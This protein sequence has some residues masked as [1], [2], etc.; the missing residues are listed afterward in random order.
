MYPPCSPP[1]YSIPFPLPTLT[2][3]PP[4]SPLPLLPPL[5]SLSPP[6]PPP[7][8]S[9]SSSSPTLASFTSVSS[10]GVSDG[11]E[12][13]VDF[14]I[15]VLAAPFDGVGVAVALGGY[16]PTSLTSPYH[17]DVWT[18]SPS[19]SFPPGAT[20][21]RWYLNTALAPWSP[22]SSQSTTTDGERL[23]LIMTGGVDATINYNDVW[24]MSFDTG[25][26]TTPA[27]ILWYRLTPTPGYAPR[28]NAAFY[29]VNDWLFL[30][31]GAQGTSQLVTADYDD[32]W[33][34]ADYGS[35]WTQWPQTG[36]GTGRYGVAGYSEARRLFVLGGAESDN[37]V[38]LSFSNQVY[39]GYW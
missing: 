1:F 12:S 34:S 36:T 6:L 25:T 22:R 14:S 19:G 15:N 37:V 30:Y 32:V 27:A 10:A 18:F 31:G 20:A 26:A 3:H 24:Q 23:V 8:L 35:T 38:G 7:S 33:M 39:V 28:R 2:S 29:T 21:S 4:P 13:R 9:Y 17:N 5:P 11:L 16:D